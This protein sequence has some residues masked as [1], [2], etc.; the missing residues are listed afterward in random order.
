MRL[1]LYSYNHMPHLGLMIDSSE[2]GYDI[3]ITIYNP[4]KA[5]ENGLCSRLWN[6][7]R[8]YSQ[9]NN[10]MLLPFSLNELIPLENPNSYIKYIEL[11]E[12]DTFLRERQKGAILFTRPTSL[13][14]LDLKDLYLNYADA[15]R[16]NLVV[17]IPNSCISIIKDIY[18]WKNKHSH[19]L[20][21]E[22]ILI[23]DNVAEILQLTLIRDFYIRIVGDNNGKFSDPG[24]CKNDIEGYT[25]M[26]KI[27]KDNSSE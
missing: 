9:L 3:P 10:D 23:S 14:E 26:D 22:R 15:K 6:I 12:Y 16:C 13:T 4:T 18:N 27:S 7:S 21:L 2:T 25:R 1:G 17:R 11:G 8:G 24:N 5:H 20:I 19:C